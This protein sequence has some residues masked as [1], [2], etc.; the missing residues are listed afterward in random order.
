[1]A[2]SRWFRTMSPRPIR[3]LPR[4]SILPLEDRTVPASIAING[5]GFEAPILTAG[6]FRY[7]PSGTPWTFSG[8][9]GVTAN[10]S[11]FTSSNPNAPQGNQ[12]L[13]LQRD[14]SISQ[15]RTF[16]DGSYTLSFS[17][18]QRGNVPSAQT[19]QVLING[20]VVGTFN[21]LSGTAYTTLTTSSF[22]VASDNYTITFRGTNVN[23]GD[24][25]VLIDQ[26]MLNSQ[27]AALADS[28]F[29]FP[30]QAPGNFTY[31]PSGGPW[32]FDG[33]SGLASNGSGFTSGNA[34]APQGNQ[35][36]MLQKLARISEVVDF[37]AGTYAI[38]FNAAQRGNLP[39]A[40]TFQVLI[41]GN[42]VGTF[43]NLSGT[44]YTLLTT[45][46]FGVATGQHQ[47][48]FQGTNLNGGDNTAFID[49]VSIEEQTSSLR[50]SGFETPAL[51]P[52]AFQYNPTGTAWTFAA[53]AGVAANGS[54]FTSGNSSAPQGNQ[55]MFVQR[56]SSASQAVTF[57][58][59]TYAVSFS[60]AQRG[61]VSSAQTLQVLIDGDVVGTFN[62][63][64]G[65]AYTSLTTSSFTVT[66]GTH[67]MTFRGT[68]IYGGDNTM[69]V[70]QVA[71][72]EQ[73]VAL[74]DS[75]FESPAVAPG[76]FAYAPT[77]SSWTFTGGAGL[78][79]NVSGFTSGNPGAPQGNQV[80][81]LQRESSVSQA[82]TLATGTYMVNFSAAQRG[83]LPS[84]QTFQVLIDGTVVGTFNNL[85]SAVYS[86]LTT[87]TFSLNAGTHT[88]T[89]RGT[90]LAGGDNTVLIDQVSFVR[91]ISGVG[92]ASFEL[93]ALNA[94]GYAYNPAGSLW[95]FSGT[96]GVASNGSP[97]TSGNPSAPRGNQVAVLQG[98]SSIS[99]VVA[100]SAGDYAINFSAAQR[101]NQASAQTFRVL[102]DG[103]IVGSYNTFT[104][105][106]YSMLGTSDFNLAEGN[107]SLTFEG[108]N[109]N[110]GDNAVFLDL[111]T[112]TKL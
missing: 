44:G 72:N 77:G 51:N 92:D 70:D 63:L 20:V 7:A 58:A 86:N 49:D 94:G 33:G 6:A 27:P 84:A 31:N 41:D 82:M 53:G 55:A 81:F 8:G 35:V 107:H 76:G 106:G 99:Q 89:F 38:K 109:L 3:K 95:T 32:A 104:G 5:G 108:T 52:G 80:V 101:G 43:N 93:P 103:N 91:P 57:A 42:V 62:N 68:N 100:L 25:T 88:L 15:Q 61:N 29:E 69:F 111:V 90:N 75:A 21:N 36:A 83:N 74:D 1:M 47:I 56:E 40:Q 9:A 97:F 22:N 105:I 54:G 4:L 26:V 19:L 17:A 73:S 39:S 14:G 50:D 102:V 23:G 28:G 16:V 59:G 46:S 13:F 71:V 112:I 85:T 110:G 10:S 67:T 60:A 87:L 64:T 2:I 45:S 30:A 34:A 65:T 37:V 78:A 12:V 66:G 96:A 48:A 98:T 11:G 24:N 18:A 79:G